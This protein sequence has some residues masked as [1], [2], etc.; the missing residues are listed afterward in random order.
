MSR[1]TDEMHHSAAFVARND[2]AERS[3]TQKIK[4]PKRKLRRR[5][6]QLVQRDAV[7]GHVPIRCLR[8]VMADQR[9]NETNAQRALEAL[10]E[11]RHRTRFG[12]IKPPLRGFGET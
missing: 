5:Y 12:A 7:F 11:T 4:W 3:R 10:P 8:D 6:V 2:H 1:V 9:M